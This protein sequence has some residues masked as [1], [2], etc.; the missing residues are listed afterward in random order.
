MG[1]FD[2]AR[3]LGS[4][5]RLQKPTQNRFIGLRISTSGEK[6]WN[7]IG[8]VPISNLSMVWVRIFFVLVVEKL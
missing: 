5:H 3:W 1:P 2:F 6:L 7:D 4:A 8:V